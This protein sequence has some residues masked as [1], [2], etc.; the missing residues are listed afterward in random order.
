MCELP[1]GGLAAT[2]QSK[3]KAME[4]RYTVSPS[5]LCFMSCALLQNHSRYH[6]QS[7]LECDNLERR[8]GKIIDKMDLEISEIRKQNNDLDKQGSNSNP[9]INTAIVPKTPPGGARGT[10]KDFMNGINNL[11]GSGGAGPNEEVQNLTKR[12]LELNLPEEAK[13]LVD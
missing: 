3:K 11:G 2:M 13:K 6:K 10:F 9:H 1:R 8:I 5:K 12:L 4:L 7:L